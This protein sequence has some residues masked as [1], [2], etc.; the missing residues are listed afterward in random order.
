MVSVTRQVRATT[1]SARAG[2]P[3]PGRPLSS[4]R[5]EGDPRAVQGTFLMDLRLLLLVA[6]IVFVAILVG[7]LTVLLYLAGGIALGST[8]YTRRRL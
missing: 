7:N 4:E 6:A 8:A 1:S 2:A 5:G 3:L